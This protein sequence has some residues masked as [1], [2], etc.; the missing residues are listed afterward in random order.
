MKLHEAARI[1]LKEDSQKYWVIYFKELR[2]SHYPVE[3]S[4]HVKASTAEEAWN[5]FIK[6]LK[7]DNMPINNIEK[8]DVEPRG[9]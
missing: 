6:D 9:W 1:I 8:I 3:Q 2:S 4:T 7:K 5:K